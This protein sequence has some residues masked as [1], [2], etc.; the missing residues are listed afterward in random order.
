MTFRS[1]IKTK[2][3]VGAFR[4][5]A[6][7]VRGWGASIPSDSLTRTAVISSLPPRLTIV[8]HY[9]DRRDRRPVLPRISESRLD[10]KRELVPVRPKRDIS[11]F[12]Y[13]DGNQAPAWLRSERAGASSVFK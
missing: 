13:H 1:T 2:A 8:P 7:R 5:E 12:D 3:P 6:L 4:Q 9:H 10:G 11:G